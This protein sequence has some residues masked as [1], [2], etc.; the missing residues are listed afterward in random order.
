MIHPYCSSGSINN[1][2]LLPLLWL[3]AVSCLHYM[4][5]TQKKV[6]LVYKY[7]AVALPYITAK[8]LK[9]MLVVYNTHIH[10]GYCTTYSK[11]ILSYI[12]CS[13]SVKWIFN[14]AVLLQTSEHMHYKH[15]S[16]YFTTYNYYLCVR[17]LVCQ[18]CANHTVITLSTHHPL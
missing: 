8:I 12:S 14:M 11:I 2:S 9:I 10:N 1:R 4:Y 13:L 17:E 15:W 3:Y 7:W 18:D 5:V 16:C 6:I